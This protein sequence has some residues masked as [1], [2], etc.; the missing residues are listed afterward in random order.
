MLRIVPARIYGL[1]E[2]FHCSVSVFLLLVRDVDAGH[3][4]G[5]GE[6]VPLAGVPAPVLCQLG[7]LSQRLGELSS[8]N[9]RI[10]T[11]RATVQLHGCGDGFPL[12]LAFRFGV[13]GLNAPAEISSLSGV[14]ALFQG[15]LEFPPGLGIPIQVPVAPSASVWPR[16][17]ISS[18]ADR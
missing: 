16:R 13:N 5:A 9:K 8:L 10:R 7:D 3:R 4:I 17:R 18:A 12:S 11:L 1:L 14:V 6:V 15:D 2:Q